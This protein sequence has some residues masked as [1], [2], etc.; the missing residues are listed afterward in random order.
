[1][2]S[3][4]RSLMRP[5]CSRRVKRFDDGGALTFQE[6]ADAFFVQDWEKSNPALL[7]YCDAGKPRPGNL[8]VQIEL[9]QSKNQIR[10]KGLEY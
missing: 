4:G 9:A 8:E 7:N 6:E 2:I 3:T 1:M 5:N 10:T